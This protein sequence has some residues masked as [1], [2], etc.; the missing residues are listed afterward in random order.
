M[1]PRVE[2]ISKETAH[3]NCKQANSKLGPNISNLPP[4]KTFFN[5]NLN[6]SDNIA[7]GFEPVFS[8]TR[9]TSMK[10]QVR[11]SVTDKVRQ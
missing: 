4:N 11:Q 3:A 6:T 7:I 8:A 10:S 9:V 2:C 1:D 5:A